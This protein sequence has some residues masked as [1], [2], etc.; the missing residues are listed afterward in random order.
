MRDAAIGNGTSALDLSGTAK[1]AN[2]SGKKDVA[3]RAG[4]FENALGRAK[5]GARNGDFPA[6]QRRQD[7]SLETKGAQPDQPVL[8]DE[9]AAEPGMPEIEEDAPKT[10]RAG[11]RPVIDIRAAL[12]RAETGKTETAGKELPPQRALGDRKT[13]RDDRGSVRTDRLRGAEKAA[14]LAPSML[15]NESRDV[16]DVKDVRRLH[17]DIRLR[18]KDADRTVKLRKEVERAAVTEAR[19]DAAEAADTARQDSV[20]T[21]TLSL[22]QNST[23]SAPQAA[24]GSRN[25]D[26]PQ[27]EAPKGLVA[28]DKQAPVAGAQI[29]APLTAP[30]TQAAAP[31]KAELPGQMTMPAPTAMPAKMELPMQAAMPAISAKTELP[32]Q[33]AT[34]AILAKTELSAQAATPAIS[35]KAEMPATMAM[36]AMTDIPAK[37]ELSAKTAM[38]ATEVPAEV[39]LP[40]KMAAPAAAAEILAATQAIPRMDMPRKV[41]EPALDAG[42]PSISADDADTV[43]VDADLS[44]IR[45]SQVAR[46][47]DDRIFRF[48]RADGR[49]QTLDMTIG[50]TDRNESPRSLPVENVTVLDSRR[51]LAL[52]PNTAA[53]AGALSGDPEW[54]SAMQ[55]GAALSNAASQ[56]STGKVVNTLKIQIHPMTLGAV[57][58]TMRLAGDE[59]TIDLQVETSA[60]YRQLSD[61]QR[62]LVESLR[63][64]GFSV[65]QVTVTLV[66]TPDKADTAAMQGNGQ[67]TA[68]N[69]QQS[70]Q[71]GGASARR[72]DRHASG[73]QNDRGGSSRVQEPQAGDPAAAGGRP[74]HL[75]L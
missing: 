39:E 1:G 69:G 51:Y 35:A 27:R 56:A 19:K 25:P 70:A 41:D 73:Q 20:T 45:P 38:P 67:N 18:E 32:M 46:G 72:D 61:D 55:P 60:A 49:G 4:D 47:D 6:T 30:Q 64:Q 22:L 58:A 54:T 9:S 7:S 43:D 44:D 66:S 50:G 8:T 23:A 10:A 59:L 68:S 62:G 16:K 14:D 28:A 52:S 21:D 17:D 26:Q 3:A 48:S 40:A 37:A 57:T 31:A 75:Y 53:V 29:L 34:P 65:D 15:R 24:D 63:A 36:P 12:G 74:D 5:P 13:A 71:D 11:T 42:M 2:R 33:A